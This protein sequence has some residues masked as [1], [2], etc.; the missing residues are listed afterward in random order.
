MRCCETMLHV[1]KRCAALCFALRMPDGLRG[2]VR[3]VR[4]RASRAV[5]AA[6]DHAAN[7]RAARSATGG[8][9]GGG[10]SARAV[11]TDIAASSVYR[12]DSAQLPHI[13]DGH[14]KTAWNARTGELTGAW[15][16]VRIPRDAT[17]TSIEMTAGFTDRHRAN[18]FVHRQSTHLES[19]CKARGGGA[20]NIC[21][22]C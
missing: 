16:D 3:E 1:S 5:D 8:C 20:R 15:I 17:V 7:D 21:A 11:A 14:L 12:N 2:R 22:R 9:G 18:G 19:A 13:A 4:R 10:R 6:S